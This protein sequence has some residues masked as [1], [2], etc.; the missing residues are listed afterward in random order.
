MPTR[1]SSRT[2][3]GGSR[4]P[5]RRGS[6]PRS[7][8]ASSSADATVLL[9]DG[10]PEEGAGRPRPSRRRP[11]F[12]GRMG[13]LL[14]V[15]AVLAISYASS[16]RAYLHQRELIGDL[17]SDIAQREA[18]I[19]QLERE[20]QRWEDPA[21]VRSQARARFGY[22]MPGQVGFQVLDEEG[23]P[24]DGREGLHDPDE[25]VPEQ[26]TPWWEEAWESVELAGNPPKP[27][28]GPVEMIDGVKVDERTQRR[29]DR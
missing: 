20:K 4:R 7:R 15:L 13:V 3:P 16:L 12:T 8:A 10:L 19:A 23:Q 24:I 2:G 6:A 11:R 26:P 28:Q 5:G 9:R 18:A 29:A 21:Y 1:P 14:L 27:D 22:L 17:N 25:V